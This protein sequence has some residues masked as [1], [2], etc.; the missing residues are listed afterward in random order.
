MRVVRVETSTPLICLSSARIDSGA[1]S[2]SSIPMVAG[3]D[4]LRSPLNLMPEDVRAGLVGVSVTDEYGLEHN[5]THSLIDGPSGGRRRTAFILRRN[6]LAQAS[7]WARPRQFLLW[8][9]PKK[10]PGMRALRIRREC[11]RLE[12]EA[13]TIWTKSLTAGSSAFMDAGFDGSDVRSRGES[14]LYRSTSHHVVAESDSD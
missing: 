5:V 1:P 10:L 9:V 4:M 2:A 6:I 12:A 13:R 11:D 7:G 8:A 3:E 14:W